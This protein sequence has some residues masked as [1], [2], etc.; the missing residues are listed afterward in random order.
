MELETDSLTRG[1]AGWLSLVSGSAVSAQ[2]TALRWVMNGLS[3]SSLLLSAIS[4]LTF[5]AFCLL[6]FPAGMAA[7]RIDRRRILKIINLVLAAASGLLTSLG[8]YVISLIVRPYAARASSHRRENTVPNIAPATG[9]G[10]FS[11]NSPA[12]AA[13]RLMPSLAWDTIS[14][15]Q[16][17]SIGCTSRNAIRGCTPKPSKIPS[18]WIS[19]FHS[20][21]Q[22]SLVDIGIDSNMA[23]IAQHSS[24]F[25]YREPIA[26]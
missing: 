20:L 12:S 2:D 4:T 14:S 18:N 10:L 5:F 15:F 11:I 3:A 9:P 7:D 21:V 25:P 17:F 6:T 19:G 13:I 16:L 8:V 1:A 26:E 24:N 22:P 23:C